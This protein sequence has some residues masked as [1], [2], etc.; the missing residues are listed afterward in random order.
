MLTIDDSDLIEA[1]R[2]CWERLKLVVEPTGCLGIAALRQGLV[3]DVKG[4][5][6]GVILSGGNVDLALALKLLGRPDAEEAAS[7][8]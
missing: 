2:F 8:W 7:T 1:M 3:P 6:V 4:A 5:R